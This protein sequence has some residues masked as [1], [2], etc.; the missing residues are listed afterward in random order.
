MFKR[1]AK[2]LKTEEAVIQNLKIDEWISDFCKIKNSKGERNIENIIVFDCGTNRGQILDK[3]IQCFSKAK[4]YCFEP[5]LEL[6]FFLK[7]KYKGNNNIIVENF[8]VGASDSE[9]VKF[10]VNKYDETS[11]ILKPS[12]FMKERKIMHAEKEIEV[13]MRRIDKYC[14]ERNI[15]KIDLI[16]MDLQGYE[17]EALKGCGDFL[18]KIEVIYAE[19]NFIKI[20]ENQPVFSEIDVF[21]SSKGFR[22]YNIYNMGR[23]SKSGQLGAGDAMW[24]ND[25]FYPYIFIPEKWEEDMLNNLGL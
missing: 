24:V 3:I 2:I 18:S 8:A 16:K 5:I 15:A 17:L 11:S 25:K 9:E 23:N 6:V 13:M 20:Y 12:E 21:L 4:Y 22:L 14:E 7:D 10:N 19:V 1:M